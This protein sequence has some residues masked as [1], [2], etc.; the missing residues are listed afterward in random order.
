MKMANDI[1]QLTQRLTR[2]LQKHQ[3]LNFDMTNKHIGMWAEMLYT[4][5]N[6]DLNNI[7]GKTLKKWWIDT[8]EWFNPPWEPK[9]DRLTAYK[10]EQAEAEK[11]RIKWVKDVSRWFN[12]LY[13]DAPD[14][15]Y[16]AFT[17]VPNDKKDKVEV[18]SGKF[19]RIDNLLDD[20]YGD[21][22]YRN[23][24]VYFSIG[25]SRTQPSPYYS[26]N[27]DMVD[28]IPI[29]FM[30]FDIGQK[31]GLPKSIDVAL[32]ALKKCPS[33]PVSVLKSGGGLHVYFK[34][35]V[36]FIPDGEGKRDEF[37]AKVN[38]IM[39]PIYKFYEENPRYGWIFD[40]RSNIANA[41]RVP[42][43]INW[44]YGAE[45]RRGEILL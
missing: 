26:I 18:I 2:V 23:R 41:C 14:D 9:I 31:K 19:Y 4:A 32:D 33:K 6:N 44:K 22:L 42:G 25:L 12:E 24:D 7:N 20:V 13:F 30:D 3:I 5:N 10:V 38:G 28:Y 17:T 29:V 39:A 43:L 36:H 35:P 8:D 37:I 45:K 15:Y 27:I 1:D 40:N 34:L 21:N 11:K 16:I